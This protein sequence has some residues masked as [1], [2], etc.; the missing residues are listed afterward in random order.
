[1]AV[2]TSSQPVLVKK[3]ERMRFICTMVILPMHM[4]CAWNWTDLSKSTWRGMLH[5]FRKWFLG[6]TIL[7]PAALPSLVVSILY[8]QVRVESMYQCTNNTANAD[9][10][11]R[12]LAR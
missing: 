6:L 5:G 8:M 3:H 9:P 12:R 10:F 1:M 4:A 2:M 11:V 7:A